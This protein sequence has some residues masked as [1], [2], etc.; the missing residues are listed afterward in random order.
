MEI[1]SLV[2][3]PNASVVE[4]SVCSTV[5]S[6]TTVIVRCLSSTRKFWPKTLENE[7][8]NVEK[9]VCTTEVSSRMKLLDLISIINLYV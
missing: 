1:N 7:T 3:V 8:K 2:V 5:E 4:I 6:C 9:A